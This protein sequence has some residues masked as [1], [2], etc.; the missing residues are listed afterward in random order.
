MEG[1][2]KKKR[3]PKDRTMENIQSEEQKNNKLGGKNKQSFRN[4]WDYDKRSNIY[5]EEM[6]KTMI[7]VEVKGTYREV[8]FLHFTQA[9]E[10]SSS[11]FCDNYIEC[12]T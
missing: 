7:K 1:T 4:L 3:E 10:I 5:K 11:V 8:K 6:F 12:N 2:E 9:D